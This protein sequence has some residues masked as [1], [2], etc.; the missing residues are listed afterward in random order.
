[1]KLNSHVEPRTAIVKWL[2]SLKGIYKRS[3]D[4][5]ILKGRYIVTIDEAIRNLKG[6]QATGL[7]NIPDELLKAHQ[8]CRSISLS[9]NTKQ[10]HSRRLEE[11]ANSWYQHK[12]NLPDWRGVT[13]KVVSCILSSIISEGKR[14]AVDGML[15]W[16]QSCFRSG[17]S[18]TDEITLRIVDFEMGWSILLRILFL[19]LLDL[20]L[21]RVL[22]KIRR[23]QWRL[24]E[25]LEDLDL[26]DE[27]CYFAQSIRD[28]QSKVDIGSQKRY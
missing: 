2:K 24:T 8:D 11:R 9:T 5:T 14:E 15:R 27:I 6:G 10:I 23:L 20:I 17:R 7:D 12:I 22:R 19:M 21:R 26:A 3:K 16:E 13:L 28:M 18:C 25:R 1:M 4:S